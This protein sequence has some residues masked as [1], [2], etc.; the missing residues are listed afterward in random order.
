MYLHLMCIRIVD[1]SIF[2][3]VS[4]TLNSSSLTTH[5]MQPILGWKE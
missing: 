5:Y 4:Q 1:I 3:V 2:H